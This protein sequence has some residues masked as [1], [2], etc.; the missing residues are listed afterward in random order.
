M[1]LF[2][3]EFQS[4]FINQLSNKP[5]VC[6]R[7]TIEIPERALVN[8]ET[9]LPVFISMVKDLGVKVTIEH[10]GAQLAGLRHLKNLK[11]DYLKIDGRFIRDI[12]NE[13]DNQL[14][15]SSLISIAHGLNIKII[16]ETIE[17]NEEYEWLK[18]A[19]VDFFQGYYLSAPKI[20]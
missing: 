8:D 10:F 18:T 20:L 1:S 15:V 11:P 13:S 19:G 6:A 7:L 5:D 3:T 9:M 14:F 16:A 12:A 2:D 17:S 4:W